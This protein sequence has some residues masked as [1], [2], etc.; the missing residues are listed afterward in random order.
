M[1]HETPAGT[2]QSHV[3]SLRTGR[4]EAIRFH[5][6]LLGLELVE[7]DDEGGFARLRFPGGGPDLL[8]EQAD[9]SGMGV[10]ALA[11]TFVGPSVT[12]DDV[13]T[14][15]RQLAENSVR[16]ESPP[17]RQSWGGLPAHFYDPDG[18]VW[19]LVEETSGPGATGAP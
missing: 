4:E 7:R 14:A 2:H 6:D 5:A 10:Q 13:E 1:K 9:R 3:P 17:S 18:N 16:F 11:G 12:A 8:I 15:H 19:S